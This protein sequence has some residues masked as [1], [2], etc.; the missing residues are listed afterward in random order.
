MSGQNDIRGSGYRCCSSRTLALTMM[1]QML[2]MSMMASGMLPISLLAGEALE[3]PGTVLTVDAAAAKFAVKKDGG[4]TRFTFVANDKTAFEGGPTSVADLK[5][6]DHVIVLYRMQ[7]SQ[8]VAQ[9][10]VKVK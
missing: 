4:G 10:V 5:K 1:L 9:K 6:D 2:V 8:Y 7:G 3:F